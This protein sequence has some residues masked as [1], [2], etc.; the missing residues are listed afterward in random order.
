MRIAVCNV[1]VIP[2]PPPPPPGRLVNGIEDKEPF[3]NITSY[4]TKH[5]SHWSTMEVGLNLNKG[6]KIRVSLR[7]R[8]EVHLA[9]RCHVNS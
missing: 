5:E 3:L 4:S 1:D 9:A 2:P 7:H 8:S 6:K